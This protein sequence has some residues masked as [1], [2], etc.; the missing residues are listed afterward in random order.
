M[1]STVSAQ[2]NKKF[3]YICMYHIF[4]VSHLSFIYHNFVL[5]RQMRV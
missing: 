3:A 1:E 2:V 5:G 4:H